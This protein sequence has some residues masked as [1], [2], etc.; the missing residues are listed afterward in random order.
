ME[1]QLKT[2][3]TDV[4][5]GDT[6]IRMLGGK[7]PMELIVGRVD[8][9]F[10]YTKSPDGKVKLSEGWK[11]RRD[12]GAEVDADLGWDGITKTGS[13]LKSIK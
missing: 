13:Y 2:S 3:F 11:F 9:T 5:E 6:V 10:I 12:N 1:K 4:K 8:D 7:I